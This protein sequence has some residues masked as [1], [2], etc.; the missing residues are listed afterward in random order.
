[1]NHNLE[2]IIREIISE[3]VISTQKELSDILKA[4]GVNI[5]QS[6]LSKKLR[7]FNIIR[8]F[9]ENGESYYW[10]PHKNIQ[11]QDSINRFVSSIADNGD[12][13]ILKSHP[14]T[15]RVVGQIIDER[16]PKEKILGTIA[17]NNTIIVIP[18]N[19]KTIKSLVDELRQN[20]IEE[21]D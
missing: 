21:F 5:A 20:F 4:Y 7:D 8:R 16:F 2:K 13:I 9:N 19:R 17:D 14:G 6:N 1:M 11:I 10:A 3:K 12:I 15:A 18:K